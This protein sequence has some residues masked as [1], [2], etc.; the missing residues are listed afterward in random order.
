MPGRLFFLCTGNYYRSRFAEVLFNALA[1]EVG[2]PWR[3][4]SRG[5]ALS[6]ANGG[7]ISPYALAGLAARGLADD[8]PAHLPRRLD[9]GD[10]AAADLIVAVSEAEHRPL[11]VQTFPTWSGRITYWQVEDVDQTPA[12]EALAALEREV[13][14]LIDRLAATGPH[15][16]QVVGE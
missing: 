5:L 10:L 1:A 3:A 2:L 15:A 13:R 16:G 9:E 14:R 6:A 7:P 11:L 4:E 12:E 8:Q